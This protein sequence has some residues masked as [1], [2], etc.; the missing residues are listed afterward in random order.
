MIEIVR[1]QDVLWAVNACVGGEEALFLLDTAAG[2]TTLDRA[3][4]DRLGVPT[5]GCFSGRRMSGEGVTLDVAHDVEIA[6]GGRSIRHETVGVFDLA[7]LLPAGWPPVGG[8][9]GLPTFERFVTTLD[10]ARRRLVLDADPGPEARELHARLERD[11]P[12]LDLFVEVRA[13]ARSLWLAVDTGNTGPVI[14][15]PEAVEG[16][17]YE[18]A[19]EEATLDVCGLGTVRTPVVVK[20][21]RYDGNLGAPFFASR[22]LTL[23]LAAERAWVSRG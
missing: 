14:L 17:G 6:L 5:E 20:A 4:A 12:S 11:G 21:I 8:A 13:R 15:S 22:A 10:F 1:Y 3:L 19:P 7:A 2:L 18:D 16:L 9:I 23:D